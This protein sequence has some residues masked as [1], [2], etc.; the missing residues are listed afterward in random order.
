VRTVVL[1]A[2]IHGGFKWSS[3]HLE[4]EG[5][6]NGSQSGAAD[7]HGGA[8]ADAVTGAAAAGSG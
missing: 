6:A 3:Q 4:D 7:E 5:V 8:Q 1:S 2:G